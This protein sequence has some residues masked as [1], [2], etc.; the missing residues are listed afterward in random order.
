MFVS[1]WPKIDV[2][3]ND[4]I[5]VLTTG[6]DKEETTTTTV[7]LEVKTTRRKTFREVLQ[8]EFGGKRLP[9][10]PLDV[11]ES[12]IKRGKSF[13]GEKLKKAGKAT[14]RVVGEG[15][16]GLYEGAFEEEVGKPS[17]KEVGRLTTTGLRKGTAGTIRFMTTPQYP[18][19]QE[20]FDQF[21]RPITQPMYPQQVGYPRAKGEGEGVYFG[22]RSYYQ[23]PQRQ[24][25]PWRYYKQPPKQ[26][27]QPTWGYKQSYP[28]PPRQP[29]TGIS[30]MQVKGLPP[31]T[32]KS[33]PKLRRKMIEELMLHYP[34]IYQTMWR[35]GLTADKMV[36]EIETQYPSLHEVLLEKAVV[37]QALYS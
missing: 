22:R 5:E 16:S 15:I 6:S 12:I 10:R 14:G 30:G 23:Q 9:D 13:N 2:N 1:R 11:S 8:S 31:L 3:I 17:V 35:Q 18:Q 29:Q 34:E 37:S 28:Q 21:G 33:T 19:Y 20:E 36:K 26:P 32:P 27:H 25:Q 7:P 24:Q 4:P